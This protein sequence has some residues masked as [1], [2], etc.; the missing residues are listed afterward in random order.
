VDDRAAGPF[1]LAGLTIP[2]GPHLSGEILDQL[3]DGGYE[4]AELAALRAKLRPDDVVME[5]G[6]GIGVLSAYCARVVGSSSVFTFEAN[7]ALEAPIRALYRDNGVSPTLEIC[8]LGDRHGEERLYV[9]DAFWTSS[10]AASR[11]SASTVTVPVRP[12]EEA[13][14]SVSPTLLIVD[15]EG[16]ELD[17][18][19]ALRL[20][21]VRTVVLEL[22]PDVTGEDGCAAVLDAVEAW[23]FAFD[24]AAS[25]DDV[26]VL[27]RTLA[28]GGAEP[29]AD[30]LPGRQKA[31]ATEE[32][33][34]LVPQR[35]AFV[36]VDSGLWWESGDF[37][38]RTRRFLVERNG[39]DWGLPPDTES[40]I[41]ELERRRAEG[42]RWLA[43][44]W[45]A[46]WWFD[47][48]PGLLDTLRKRFACVAE[49]RRLVVF[50]LS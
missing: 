3:A 14:R 21:G 5:L 9:H 31:R 7:P 6:A 15:I 13:R 35:G 23:G 2:G 47:E 20:D 36:L 1:E 11:A 45:T 40:A 46:F 16:G 42:T 29:A 44:A 17:L 43:F 39:D 22:H 10:T 8:M 50:D 33:C 18:L 4:R 26:Y 49:S 28:N 30:Y 24:A 38:A 27:D 37:G 19:P 12:F 48:Y 25:S 32:L 34:E 41:E